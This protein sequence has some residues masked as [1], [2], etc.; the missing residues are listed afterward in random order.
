MRCA[1]VNPR[2]VRADGGP[3]ADDETPPSSG[4]APSRVN[5]RGAAHEL[6]APGPVSRGPVSSRVGASRSVERRVRGATVHEAF[7][8]E[9][10]HV[11]S[12]GLLYR[13]RGSADRALE[14]GSTSRSSTR[15]GEL[16]D[17]PELRPR[18]RGRGEPARERRALQ[19]CDDSTPE[20]LERSPDAYQRVRFR[21]ALRTSRASG[22]ADAGF[23][24][25]SSRPSTIT[26][27]CHGGAAL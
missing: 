26:C 27:G 25:V 21:S 11:V 5:V 7:A 1:P 8:S 18:P 6:Q 14:N 20:L 12:E 2:P 4:S 9:L 10:G 24:P 3:V 17:L 13:S 16:C 15:N 19:R 23:W 22:P